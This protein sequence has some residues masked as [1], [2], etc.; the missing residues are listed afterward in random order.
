MLLFAANLMIDLSLGLEHKMNVKNPVVNKVLVR[1]AKMLAKVRGIG[2][3]LTL[4]EGNSKFA[5]N[6][7]SKI[8]IVGLSLAQGNLSGREVCAHRSEACSKLCVG[9]Q[10]LAR[11]F[12]SIEKRRIE[13]TRFFSEHPF[14]FKVLLFYEIDNER[15]RCAKEGS[16][17]AVRLNTF[18][19]LPFPTMW[20]EEIASRPD[21]QFF[22]YTKAKGRYYDFLDGKLPSNYHL[23]FSRSERTQG[24]IVPYIVSRGGSVAVPFRVRRGKPLPQT[25]Q[26]M[27]VIDGDLTDYRPSD[28]KGCI[29]GLRAKG[30]AWSD[31]SGFVVDCEVSHG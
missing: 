8:R 20:Q 17:L 3:L 25:W 26:G 1:K 16:T 27:P 2:R 5:K 13:K 4:P 29:V 31:D 24:S 12:S 7:G 30:T 23:T 11:V 18:S 19:D 6:I 9:S 10:G 14:L 21:V 22:D 15:K 28:P